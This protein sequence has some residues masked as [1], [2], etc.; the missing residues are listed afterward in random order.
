M[1]INK[2]F[3]VKNGLEVNTSL[4]VA[5]S[6]NTRVGVATTSPE[7]LLHVN[8]GIGATN[9][10]VTGLSTVV[11]VA[12]FQDGVF[13]AGISTHIG[14][15]TFQSNVFVDGNLN[16]AGSANL[17][18]DTTDNTLGD[19]DTGAVQIDGGAGIALNLSVGAG[20]SVG[21]NVHV[22]GVSTFA[23]RV[24]V[25]SAVTVDNG[26]DVTG[27]V[28][29]TGYTVNRT[30][31]IS[32]ARELQNIASLD[33]TTTATIESAIA[34]G[35][36]TFDDLKVTGITT[37]GF[38][39]ATTIQI[40]NE[41]LSVAGVT[42][43]TGDLIVGV[44]TLFADVSTGRVGIGTDVPATTLDVAGDLTA[45]SAK[46]EDLTDNRV[47]IAGTDGELEDDAN[48]TFDGS[49]LSV[50]VAL[51]VDGHTELDGVN[52]S[53]GISVSGVT[54]TATLAVTGIATAET[55]Q[56]G[57]QGLSVA[58]VST[59]TGKID[60]TGI[61][62]SAGGFNIGIQS[63]SGE[64]TTGVITALNFIGAGNTF[65][66]NASTKTVD[67]SIAGNVG[68]GGTWQSYDAGIATSKSVGVN[69]SNLDNS[70]LTGVGNSFQGLY[71][72]NGMIIVDN[73]LNGDHYIGTNYNGLMAGPVTINGTLTIDG[74]YVVV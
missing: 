1:A 58:G 32:N 43:Q 38:T 15:G 48:L 62:T 21:A 39:T 37:L 64:V 44:S 47:V 63:A 56:V 12:T 54:T 65:A 66:Y 55:L 23:D 8:G 49:T 61:V 46:V 71:I 16:V 41:G 42:T 45:N 13:I 40:G 6:D 60:A 14:V 18:T 26:L 53:E 27:V 73:T 36:N 57:D 34:S 30:Q 2:N 11:G 31:V 25:G 29:A 10:T 67:I 17:F 19:V 50:G 7:Y 33:A 51:D 9:L 70:S 5:D 22:S 72:G 4:I 69:T 28:T 35:P 68:G 24:I 59:F 52:V 20:L 3:V 74:E